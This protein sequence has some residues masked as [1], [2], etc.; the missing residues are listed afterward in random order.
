MAG[1]LLSRTA[2]DISGKN[3]KFKVD[4]EGMSSP[5]ICF[6]SN[7][8]PKFVTGSRKN[9]LQYQMKYYFFDIITYIKR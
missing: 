2:I 8:A 5:K 9:E 3:N 4:F 1:I 6:S 7:E